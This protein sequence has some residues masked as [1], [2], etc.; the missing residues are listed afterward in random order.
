MLQNKCH[1]AGALF[2]LSLEG[3]SV[4]EHCLD[5][6]RELGAQKTLLN[7]HTKNGLVLFVC[8]LNESLVLKTS[9]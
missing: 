4:V 3:A 9:N 7:R 2:S 8:L 6:Y 5:S 1:E